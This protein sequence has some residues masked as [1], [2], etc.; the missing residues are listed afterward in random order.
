[1]SFSEWIISHT[2]GQ[3]MVQLFY[4][5]LTSV[6]FAQFEIV[7]AKVCEIWQGWYNSD[8]VNSCVL[9]KPVHKI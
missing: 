8:S 7:C 5:T 1:M 2:D 9:R 6:D 3:T 4:T